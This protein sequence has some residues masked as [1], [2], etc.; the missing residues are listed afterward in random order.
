[1]VALAVEDALARNGFP[2]GEGATTA[3]PV[4]SVS[5]ADGECNALSFVDDPHGAT[6]EEI[7][8]NSGTWTVTVVAFGPSLQQIRKAVNDVQFRGNIGDALRAAGAT[9][10][11]DNSFETPSFQSTKIVHEDRI[12]IQFNQKPVPSAGAEVHQV[13]ITMTASG[14]VD[15]YNDAKQ[16]KLTNAIADAAGADFSATSIAI[17]E[18]S[19]IITA[20]IEVEDAAAACAMSSSLG[21]KLA[22]PKLASAALGITVE[23]APTI[24]AKV[25][26]A[27]SPLSPP[28]VP[29]STVCKLSALGDAEAA[30]QATKNDEAVPG[31][32]VFL[33]LLLV[34]IC[35]LPIC[36]YSFARFKYGAGKEASFFRYIFSHSNPVIPLL[37]SPFEAR[38][39]LRLELYEKKKKRPI[40]LVDVAKEEV[41][42]SQVRSE[43][44]LEECS[45]GWVGVGDKDRVS[46]SPARLSGPSSPSSPAFPTWEDG[47][48]QEDG[49]WKPSPGSPA[50]ARARNDNE[51][52]F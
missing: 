4:K 41:T 33:I 38:E 34:L 29:R 22:S 44:S 28:S 11:A 8:P 31:W 14:N 19:V 39:K 40:P 21:K 6:P 13:V 1:M 37:Y 25:I 45:Q 18:G 50:L 47:A 3:E 5:G 20:T 36:C 27:V 48:F 24:E 32:G 30:N 52:R 7:C 23:S 15:D 51:L 43:I 16:A 17:T 26:A 49:T 10:I 42:P 2:S 9:D 46:D 35:L 12:D